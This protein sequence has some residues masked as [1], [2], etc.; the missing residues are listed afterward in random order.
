MWTRREL[1]EQAKAA[2]KRNYWKAVLVT[3]L[4]GMLVGGTG[5]SASAGVS[6]SAASGSGSETADSVVTFVIAFLHETMPGLLTAI[7]I[8]SVV[9][10]VLSL[11]VSILLLNPINVGFAYF[12]VNALRGTGNVGDLGRGFDAAYKRNVGTL[13]LQAVYTF[14]WTCLLIVPGF[15]K[16]YEYS[17]I[18]YLLAD[19]PEMTRQEAFA[20]S[21]AMM[22]GNKWKAFVLDL[23]FIPWDI[24]S[25]LTLGI[26]S[27]FYVAPYRR[28]TAAA[29]Y[30]KLKAQDE[31]PM[32]EV[33]AQDA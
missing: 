26:L 3:V 11:A 29:L 8:V 18:P 31:A 12:R 33:S 28:L 23:S 14:L 5:A 27:V 15:I 32:A 4:F 19:H 13:L 7:I 22:K 16:A 20:A 30:E 10:V 6:A 24:L 25:A 2:L 17:M 9:L 21:K 1:K